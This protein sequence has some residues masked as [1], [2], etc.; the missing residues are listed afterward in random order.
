MLDSDLNMRN[1][2]ILFDIVFSTICMELGEIKVDS[3]MLRSLS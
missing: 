3:Y 2:S 1:V